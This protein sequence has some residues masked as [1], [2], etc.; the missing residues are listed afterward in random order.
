[1]RHAIRLELPDDARASR[2]QP[3][4]PAIGRLLG[5]EADLP[6]FELLTK[7]RGIEDLELANH[8]LHQKHLQTLPDRAFGGFVVDIPVHHLMVKTLA[9]ATDQVA[10]HGRTASYAGSFDAL[11]RHET[12]AREPA[13]H[14]RLLSKPG[15]PYHGHPLP[16]QPWRPRKHCFGGDPAFVAPNHRAR[17][18]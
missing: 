15:H 1:Q 8:Y 6:R 9:A 10:V 2:D 11:V 17:P 7:P 12:D 13:A 16:Q 5:N 14:L 3:V 18:P 4:S